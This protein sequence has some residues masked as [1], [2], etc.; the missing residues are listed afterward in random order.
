MKTIKRYILKILIYFRLFPCIFF[1]FNPFKI[2]E[3]KE[4]LKDVKFSKNELIL[5]IG[6]GSGLQSFLLGMRCKK[7]IGIDISEKAITT[8]KLVSQYLSERI[9][10]EFRCVRIEK[11]EFEKE[12]FNKIF[13]ICVLEHIS[14]YDKVLRESYRILKKD[15]QLIFSVDNLG[16]IK[17]KKL[18][19]KHKEDHSVQKYF[20]V[21][22]I[23][24][25]LEEI[26]FNRIEV[27]PIFKSDFAKNF[28][29][30]SI[31]NRFQYGYLNSILAYFL[32]K[33]K[34]KYCVDRENGLFLIVKC[35]K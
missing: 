9:N 30:K 8:A 12:Y 25:N 13:S 28:F 31:H 16:T 33:Y 18:L 15:S 29:I 22:E 14:N 35:N 1:K 23:K 34:E 10:S 11:A 4:L 5:D 24:T 17:D 20:K 32:I 19:L 2:Y 3:F 27:Y 6:C 21:E 7:I 26:G